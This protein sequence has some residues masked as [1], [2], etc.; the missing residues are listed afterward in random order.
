MNKLYSLLIIIILLF[1][2]VVTIKSQDNGG[3]IYYLTLFPGQVQPN[4]TVALI[5]II[6][7]SNTEISLN[8]NGSNLRENLKLNKNEA[9]RIKLT[10]SEVQALTNF[11]RTLTE[12]VISDGAVKI[13]LNGSVSADCNVITNYINNSDGFKVL[14]KSKLGVNYQITNPEKSIFNEN[15]I[16]NFAAVIGIYD[17]TKLTFKLGGCK[18]CKVI[19]EN[20]DFLLNNQLIRRTLNEG[21][22]WLIPAYGENSVITGSTIRANKPV[23]VFSGSNNAYNL[24]TSKKNYVITQELPEELWGKRYLLPKLNEWSYITPFVTVFAKNPFTDLYI[25]DLKHYTISTPG[26]IND[27]GY[28]QFNATESQYS[29]EGTCEISSDKEINVIISDTRLSNS[30]P[31]QMQ[32]LPIEQYSKSAAFTIENTSEE[33]INVIFKT[34]RNDELPTNIFI[35]ELVDDKYVK[36]NLFN[37]YPSFG[38]RFKTANEDSTFYR[39]VV[40]RF[41]NPGTYF[42]E[43]E[44]DIAVYQFGFG[45]NTSYGFAVNGKLNKP[46]NQDTLSPI[47]DYHVCC[48]CSTIL[49]K[50]T[51]QPAEDPAIRSNL[52]NIYLVSD[53]SYNAILTH[54]EF[55]AG[56]SSALDWTLKPKN[57]KFDMRAHLVV[58]DKAGN[59]TDTIIEC[60]AYIPD[61]SPTLV[62]I[63]TFNINKGKVKKEIDFEVKRYS[64]KD[65]PSDIEIYLILDS[66]STEIKDGDI[67]TNQFFDLGGLR[68]VNII[69]LIDNFKTLN[70]SINFDCNE[71]GKY[72]DSLGIVILSRNP[73]VTHKVIYFA[74]LSALVG[75]N[76]ISTED[77]D[78]GSVSLETSVT[79]QIKIFNYMLSKSETS[80]DLV[81]EN[82]K[83]NNNQVGFIGSG[84]PFEVDLPVNISKENP[85]IIKPDEF[86][87]F[88]VVFNPKGNE[89]YS[90]EIIFEGNASLP[91]NIARI[92]GNGLPSSINSEQDEILSVVIRDD[93]FRINSEMNL[94]IEKVEIYNLLGELI[95]NDTPFSTVYQIPFAN[96]KLSSGTYFLKINVNG[97]WIHK[98]IMLNH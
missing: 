76:S 81:I 19:K 31:L 37:F 82:I 32:I 25:N 24:D 96:S 4:D 65:Y 29:E 10:A 72:R 57:H 6:S 33:F 38:K 69:P 58:V 51:D 1:I 3:Q 78:F 90:S 44:E 28:R 2:S 11:S 13:T 64:D 62:N 27:V 77:Y 98:K 79:E 46:D 66:D 8:K 45:Y 26:G 20:G 39:T 41:S 5:N 43:S 52:A 73:I 16:T 91:D 42:I 83:F 30:K 34:L 56:I 50:A 88:H 87:K 86:F 59:S 70:A 54:S 18:T 67:N 93:F 40:I 75:D 17:N 53:E 35:S 23:A 14:E 94:I 68:D 48:L 21:D 15:T 22:V 47:I 85:I 84:L 55:I 71:V 97:V 60:P 89:Q 49:G 61:I 95:Y 63:G 92:S 12:Q 36:Q 7:Q 9:S 80:L 74:E